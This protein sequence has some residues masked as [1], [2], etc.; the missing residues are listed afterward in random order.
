[1]RPPHHLPVIL[2]N[3]NRG[4]LIIQRSTLDVLQLSGDGQPPK[5]LLTSPL[6]NFLKAYLAPAPENSARRLDLHCL[7][8]GK[9]TQLKLVKLHVLVEPINIP[10]TNKWIR[11]LM[12]VAYASIKPFRNVLILV[13]PV[14]G[15]GKAKNIVQDTVIPILEAAGTTVTV[16]ETTH[17]LH[18]EEIARS[19]DL[20]YDVIATASGDGLVYEVVNGLAS[21][22]DARKALQ[23]PIA[24]IPTGSAN[25]VCT[26][27][28]GVKDTFNV[29]LA[30]LN[31]IKGCNLPIDLCSVLIL[32]SM[33]RRFA[34]LSQAIGLMV[35]LDIGTENLRWMGDTRFLIGFLKGI[36]SNKGTRCRLRLKVVED[37]K[38]DMAKKAKERTQ[39]GTTEGGVTPLTNRMRNMSVDGDTPVSMNHNIRQE[40]EPPALIGESKSSANNPPKPANSNYIPDNGPIPNAR[41]LKY[42]ETWITIESLPKKSSIKPKKS[43]QSLKAPRNVSTQNEWVDG[44]EILYFYAGMMRWVARDLMQWPV[45]IPGDGLIDVVVQSVVPRLTMANAI[46]GAEKGETYW[47]DCQYYYKVSQFIAENL[48]IENQP[49][50]TIDGEAFPFESFHVEVH[51]RAANLLS[52]NGDFFTS[53]F[54]KKPT[55]KS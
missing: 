15:K 24:P 5:R 36:A 45:S 16:K 4:L 53:D 38:Q 37:D 27:L 20:V 34:F 6:T 52:L 30:A 23:T 43:T 25:A 11:M 49:L 39:Q 21:R 29:P 28:F 35:D 1:M 17:R 42:D 47:M 8:G 46:A 14:G 12:E 32:P 3:N 7:G 2:H 48:D 9:G 18:A 13:N 19:M 22:S 55:G 31:I 54:L 41:P 33:T 51:T 40:H 50:F 26:N 10:E 44:Q